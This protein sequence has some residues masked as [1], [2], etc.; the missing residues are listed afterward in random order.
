MI[1]SPTILAAGFV[2]PA[3]FITGLLF[4][5]NAAALPLFLLLQRLGMLDNLFGV[6][7]PE[8]AFSTVESRL[9][10][11]GQSLNIGVHTGKRAAEGAP[12]SL[13]LFVQAAPKK[14]PK[15]PGAA[16]AAAGKSAPKLPPVQKATA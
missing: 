6:A 16:P 12:G 10:Q 4:P 13:T 11:A 14:A 3:F 8:A 15:A 5:A 7:I 2:T 1:Q 9:R